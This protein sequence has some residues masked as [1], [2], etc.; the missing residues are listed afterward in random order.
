M[1]NEWGPR[2]GPFLFV[3]LFM[4]S[5][6]NI[7]GVNVSSIYNTD[8]TK[9]FISIVKEKRF[10]QVAITPVNSIL[11]AYSNASILDIYNNAE[12]VLCDGMAV[13]WASHFLNTPI[14]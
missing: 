12:F 13:K 4:H 1:K 14:L 11:S 2:S 3:Y 10:S 8:L 9:I 5:K 6:V 7:L